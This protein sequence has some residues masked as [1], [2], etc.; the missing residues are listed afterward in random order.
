MIKYEDLQLN[1]ALA[2]AVNDA[3]ARQA[4]VNTAIKF[5]QSSPQVSKPS[6]YGN[7][8]TQVDGIKFD[9]KAEARLYLDKIKT[10]L[11]AGEID[12]L[13]FQPKYPIVINGIKV[14]D[15]VLDFAFRELSSGE[16][17]HV[18]YKGR[19]NPLSKLK[20]KLLEAQYK[21]QVEV[22]TKESRAGWE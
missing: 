10:R 9:S 6:K 13:T 5:E 18:D 11:L 20:R 21:I 8:K 15:V 1:P 22:V 2:K 16:V 19:D 4:P 7:I 3:I 14:C 17:R 12:R